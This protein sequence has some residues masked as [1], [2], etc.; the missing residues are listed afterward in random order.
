MEKY[1]IHLSDIMRILQGNVPW[2]FYLEL[3]I[4]AVVVYLIIIVALRLM[5]KRMGKL[6]TRNELAAVSTLAAAIGI[7]LQTPDRGLLPGLLI[8]AIVVVLQRSVAGIASRKERF[9]RLTQ[10]RIST[11]V[12]DSVL[13]MN[14]MKECHLSRERIFSSLRGQ[15]I[16]HLGE[17]QRFYLEASGSF[18]IIKHAKPVPGLCVLPVIDKAFINEQPH[19]HNKKICSYCG[20]SQL[21][22]HT[23]ACS[24]CHN[25]DWVYAI[26]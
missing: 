19:D 22:E 5:G 10:G 14:A 21:Q 4:R 1:D 8:A 11:L 15:N 2:V 20:Y 26:Y 24:N 25:K 13:Q 6:L 12:S 18:T 17:V 16:R 7:P 9:E 3:V 23:T